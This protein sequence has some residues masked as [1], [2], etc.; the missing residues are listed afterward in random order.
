MKHQESKKSQSRTSKWN[1]ET[2]PMK[3]DKEIYETLENKSKLIKIFRWRGTAQNI[4]PIREFLFGSI[5]KTSGEFRKDPYS[6]ETRIHL[7]KDNF[8]KQG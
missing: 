1:K 7:L 5:S 8:D 3:R 2:K 6:E 4:F